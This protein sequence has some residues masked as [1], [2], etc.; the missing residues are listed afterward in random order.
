M[1]DCAGRDCRRL[2]RGSRIIATLR[3]N[4]A[5]VLQTYLTSILVASRPFLVTYDVI[6]NLGG[7]DQRIAPLITDTSKTNVIDPEKEGFWPM[8]TE[9]SQKR[10][11]GTSRGT[12]VFRYRE[13]VRGDL[14]G[15]CGRRAG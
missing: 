9:V 14:S 10:L 5:L 15:L 7:G 13:T 6:Q 11:L 4:K 12:L 2:D 1:P 8:P 3:E